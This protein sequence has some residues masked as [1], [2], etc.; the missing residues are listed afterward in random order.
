MRII[1]RL[2][3]AGLAL[4]FAVPIGGIVLFTALSA[5][6]G[7]A[8]ARAAPDLIASL[9]SAAAL[10]P[11]FVAEG[12]A[13]LLFGILPTLLVLPP[14]VVLL[15]GEILGARSLAFHAGLT[16]AITAAMP[17]LLRSGERAASPE[18][19]RLSLALA[20]SGATAGMVAWLIAGRSAG[21]ASPPESAP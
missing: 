10:D 17:F 1:G 19:V 5:L 12:L 4:L 7:E 6:F 18:E 2:L 14:L 16:G 3:L 9:F 15:A 13:A 21:F 8:L 11:E 20:L